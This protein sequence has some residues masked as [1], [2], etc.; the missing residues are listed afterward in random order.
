M[1]T[2]IILQARST[3]RQFPNKVFAHLDGK[4]I[5]EHCL[6][7]LKLLQFPLVVAIP[8]TPQNDILADWLI[9]KKI[10]IF[11]G[12]EHDV[13]DRF[14]QCAKE[15]DFDIIVRVCADTPFIDPFDILNNLDR[16]KRLHQ[17][18]YG[19]GSWVF[20][21][22]MLEYAW[23]NCPEAKHREHVWTGFA[24]IVD[25]EKDIERIVDRGRTIK[26]KIN[27]L[28]EAKQV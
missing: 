16:F 7:R 18:S 14:L 6:N 12:K 26:K 15:Y 8:N 3:S 2:G 13:L 27:E 22:N 1:K 9:E 5:I 20:S 19:N 11:R 4:P 28:V 24:D 17:I 10:S 21:F 23:K 25:Y